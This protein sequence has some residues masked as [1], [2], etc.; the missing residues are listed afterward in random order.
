MGRTPRIQAGAKG[1]TVYLTKAQKLAI[2]K[3]QTKH[4]EENEDDLGLTEVV[5]EAL[6]LLFARDGLSA[7]ELGMVFP[8]VEAKRAKVSVFPKRRRSTRPLA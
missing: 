1:T 5:L 8:K 4:F 3:F 6:R 2:R 7:S